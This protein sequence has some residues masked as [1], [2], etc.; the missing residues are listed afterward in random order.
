MNNRANKYKDLSSNLKRSGYELGS[1]FYVII[2]AKW[3]EYSKTGNASSLSSLIEH[4][5]FFS[6]HPVWKE[7]SGI[8]KNRQKKHSPNKFEVDF[9]EVF[10][11]WNMLKHHTKYKNSDVET[12]LS[13][14]AEQYDIKNN[15]FTENLDEK[16]AA[17]RFIETIRQPILDRESN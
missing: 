2:E 8:L 7:I 13:Y 11:L 17:D 4:F 9:D 14:I 6:T 5:P 3:D 10:G 1:E 16:Y 12:K 15:P